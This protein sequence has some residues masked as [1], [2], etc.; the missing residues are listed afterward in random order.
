MASPAGSGLSPL[1][2]GDLVGLRDPKGPRLAVIASI[3]ERRGDLRI[4]FEGKRQVQ[5]LRDLDLVMAL[6]S[7]QPAPDRVGTGVWAFDAPALEASR[8]RPRLLAQA[9]LLLVDA[10]QPVS[11][12]DLV[13]L[14]A[15]DDG[16]AHRAGF[17]LELQGPQLWF[18]Q[19]QSLFQPRPVDELRQLRRQRRHEALLERRQ[20]AWH[21]LLKARLPLDPDQLAPRERQ[22]F[23]R[24]CAGALGPLDTPWPVPLRR[25]LEAARCSDRPADLRHLLFDLGH[26][27]PHHLAT[28]P[29]TCWA[30]G[31][32]ADHE[33]LAAELAAA[34]AEPHPSDQGRIDLTDQR[35]VTIDDPETREIDDALGL[36]RDPQGRPR[37]WIHIAD[38]DRLIE[39]GSPLDLEARRR[40][41]SLYLAAGS[42]PMFPLSLAAGP[43]SLRQGQ[44]CAAWSFAVVLDAHG[45]IASTTLQRT[46]ITPTYRLSYEDA[47]D[48]I[49]LAPPQEEALAE[50]HALLQGRRHWRVAQG[51]LLL[52]QPEGRIIARQQQPQL[53]V[54]EPS[55]ARLLVAEAMILAGAAVAEFGRQHELA[56]PYRSQPA[57]ELP[58]Q[59]ELDLLPA[60]PV[61]HAAIKRCLSRGHTG[62]QPA[63]HFSL[64]LPAYVQATSPIRRYS[65]LICHRQL[66]AALAAEPLSPP[67]DAEDLGA[68]LAEVEPALRE[69][70][71]ISRDDQRHWQQV[72]FEHHRQEVWE[73]LFLRWLRPQGSLALVAIEALAMELP[74]LCR[75][76]SEPGDGL[77]VRLLEVDSLADVLRLEACARFT[78]PGASPAARGPRG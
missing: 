57:A 41:A 75:E 47:E 54:V 69:G 43:M 66:A 77:Q 68:L 44:R 22:E 76:R 27:D 24:L 72:W 40:A 20:Q 61:R 52:D 51:A 2:P 39:P 45:A 5:P 6:P 56:L 18:R 3:Q 26:W 8:P 13:S 7:G 59:Q 4:G 35:C 62:F 15:D 78:G 46:W 16:P 25:A 23:D 37:I 50:L 58:T 9:W 32:S 60:G 1:H 17:W 49:E 42:V 28:L 38:P 11:L 67:L 21:A 70:L 53:E 73:G 31:F 74:M 30:Q 55:K 29:G 65:D 34:A 36:D 19:R 71:Q 63:A 10:G 33:A 14:A 48:L 12:E 64:G